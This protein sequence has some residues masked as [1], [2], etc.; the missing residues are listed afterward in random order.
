MSDLSVEQF[1]TDYRE[2]M[3][4]AYPTIAGMSADERYFATGDERDEAFARC[5][6]AKHLRRTH[7]MY[8]EDNHE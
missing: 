2:R 4:A 5:L 1:P 3:I 7:E 8:L 6:K